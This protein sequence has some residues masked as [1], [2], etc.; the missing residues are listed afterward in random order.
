MSIFCYAHLVPKVLELIRRE[1]LD[2]S[3]YDIIGYRYLLE[4]DFPS[5]DAVTNEVI[6][7]IDM[8]GGVVVNRIFRL[9]NNTLTIVVD[10]W[11]RVGVDL[12]KRASDAATY[13]ALVV[14]VAVHS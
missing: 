6:S 7:N 8:L 1:T 12:P 14:E 10:N 9:S 2:H 11:S 4:A 13:S 5:N 3:I